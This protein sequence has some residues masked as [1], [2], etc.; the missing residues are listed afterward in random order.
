MTLGYCMQFCGTC[1]AETNHRI[2]EQNGRTK[3]EC[4]ACHEQIAYWTNMTTARMILT[5]AGNSDGR[6]RQNRP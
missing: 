1:A 6:P 2:I 5:G 4:V 3:K